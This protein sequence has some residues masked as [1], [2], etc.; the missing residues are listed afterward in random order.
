MIM[1]ITHVST[2]LH[3]IV[4]F[5]DN[6]TTLIFNSDLSNSFRNEYISINIQGVPI[7]VTKFLIEITLKIFD[8]ED[9]FVYF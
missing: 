9:Q 6:L 2:F 5:L 3:E 7:K 4:N 1:S 8:R